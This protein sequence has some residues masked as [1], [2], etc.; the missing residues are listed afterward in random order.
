M[1]LHAA[2]SL[3][4]YAALALTGLAITMNTQA[5][6]DRT[7]FDFQAPTNS[8]AWQIVNDDVMGGV[9]TSRFQILTNGGAV[10]SGVVSLENNGGFASVRSSPARHDLTGCGCFVIRLRGD[11]RRY[12]FTAR[13]ETGFDAPLYQSAF[14]TKRGEWEEHRLAFKDF[15]PTFRGRT[16]TGVPPLNP[17]KVTSVGFLISDQQAGP[18]RLEM[19]C[20]R[21]AR[22][23]EKPREP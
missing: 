17:A 11:G 12:K 8:P 13:T 3:R 22:Q 9:S 15:V 14:E 19:V 10:F 6:S 18:F 2:T 1:T 23:P 21:T 4:H 5:A 20:I 7:L 16:L